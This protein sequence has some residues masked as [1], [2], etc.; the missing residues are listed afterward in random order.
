MFAGVADG[1]LI[2][3]RRE[4]PVSESRAQVGLEGANTEIVFFYNEFIDLNPA[5]RI[6]SGFDS[7]QCL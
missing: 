3:A 1:S 4:M 2:P 7:F 6:P 5:K